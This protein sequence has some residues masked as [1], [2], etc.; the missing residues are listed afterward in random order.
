MRRVPVA[1][2]ETTTRWSGGV[3]EC[4]VTI[5]KHLVLF[6][7]PIMLLIHGAT[8]QQQIPANSSS[9]VSSFRP[10]ADVARRLQEPYGK[11]VTYE[12]P[13][14]TWRGEREAMPGRN[15]DGKSELFPKMQTFFMPESRPDADLASVLE[16]TIAA[17]HQQTSGTRFKLLSSTWG[18]H[19]LPVQMRDENGRSVP[20][21]SVLDQIVTVPSEPR[22]AI[23]HLDALA[24]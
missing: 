24:A 13:V 9:L 15:P 19:I 7:L 14:L 22:S 21:I 10:L 1:G 11:V 8:A 20:A 2:M 6:S 12:E 17:Y 18:Y 23:Q 3:R 16:N 4:V 5:Y